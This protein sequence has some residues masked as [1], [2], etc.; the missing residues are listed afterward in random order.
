MS[1]RIKQHIKTMFVSLG[2]LCAVTPLHTATPADSALLERSSEGRAAQLWLWG[3]PALRHRAFRHSLTSLSLTVPSEWRNRSWVEEEGR[4]STIPQARVE[5]FLRLSPTASAWGKAAYSQ[6]VRRDLRWVSTAD[7]DLLR[8]FVLG[9][10]VGGNSRQETYAFSGGYAWQSG[11]GW[12]WGGEVDFRAVQEYRQRDP[13]MRSLVEQFTLR[14]GAARQWGK[15]RLGA[16]LSLERYKHNNEVEHVAEQG[17]VSEWPFMGMG[18]VYQRFTSTQPEINYA[19]TAWGVHLSLSPLERGWWGVATLLQRSTER[20]VASANAVPISTLRLQQWRAA[21]GWKQ[22]KLNLWGELQWDIRR[23]DEHVAGAEQAGAFPVLERL[24]LYRETHHQMSLHATA[25]GWK[26]WAVAAMVGYDG[27]HERLQ[28]VARSHSWQH[29]LA[30][31][32]ISGHKR[33]KQVLW[34]WRIEANGAWRVRQ[35]WQWEAVSTSLSPE[36]D[37]ALEQW[38]WHNHR[39]L[40]AS[41]MAFNA[42][43]RAHL[44]LRRFALFVQGEGGW[45]Q[46]VAV[47]Q[48]WR[49]AFTVGVTL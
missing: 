8:P 22:K 27:T 36:V 23:G 24:T 41:Q 37:A 9:D 25:D 45:A 17:G 1:Q 30:A 47:G 4:G 6:G 38:Q 10:S 31:L 15:Q 19:G 33:Q 32:A 13:R 46:R 40:A 2:L 49:T 3:N 26:N 29:A 7:F 44:P 12:Q 48:A 35:T 42:S 43:V 39:A 5:S 34:L 20:T 21:V 18:T 11:N 16:A 14:A 28:Q